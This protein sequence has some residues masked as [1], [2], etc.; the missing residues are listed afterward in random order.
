MVV[1]GSIVIGYQA[2]LAHLCGSALYGTSRGESL[3]AAW[4]NRP[5][6]VSV[7]LLRQCT[8]AAKLIS[9][10]ESRIPI[11][12]CASR[13]TAA[14]ALSP[15]SVL[16]LGRFH[17]PSAKPVPCRSASRTWS[18]LVS[19]RKTSRVHRCELFT[20]H[21]GSTAVTGRRDE[22][23]DGRRVQAAD[24]GR[25]GAVQPQRQGTDL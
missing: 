13:M 1:A 12:S 5:T 8:V 21:E 9:C 15:G 23:V 19:S 7:S 6:R 4:K 24:L 3:A 10:S 18:C 20:S 11:S 16:P 2:I 25:G 17:R 14:T 22:T